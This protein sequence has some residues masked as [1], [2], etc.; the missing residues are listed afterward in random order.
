[1]KDIKEQLKLVN[2]KSFKTPVFRPNLFYD[3]VYDDLLED[4]YEHLKDFIQCT[5]GKEDPDTKK[6]NSS[7]YGSWIMICTI[8]R[9]LTVPFIE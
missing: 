6:V 3:V 4:S 7:C 2:P 9:C 1:M 5:L 8:F